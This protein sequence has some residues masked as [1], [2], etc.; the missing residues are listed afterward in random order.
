MHDEVEKA[1]NE[2]YL[3][4]KSINSILS[5]HTKQ[6]YGMLSK[7]LVGLSVQFNYKKNVVKE[8]VIKRVVIIS[9]NTVYVEVGYGEV[10]YQEKLT[11]LSTE[12]LTFL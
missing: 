4:K 9:G 5:D 10:G 3:M 12:D 8:G 1:L 11:Q 6:V 7:K 2:L